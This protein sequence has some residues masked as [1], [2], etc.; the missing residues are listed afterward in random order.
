VQS[1]ECVQVEFDREF[2]DV[3]LIGSAEIVFEGRVEIP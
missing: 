3:F 2:Q 1:G